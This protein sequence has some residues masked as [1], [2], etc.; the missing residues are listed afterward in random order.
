MLD[1]CVLQVGVVGAAALVVG[2]LGVADDAVVGEVGLTVFL[3]K[4]PGLLLLPLLPPPI[5]LRPEV[6]SELTL[7]PKRPLMSSKLETLPVRDLWPG[8]QV[9]RFW[10][11]VEPAAAR[12]LDDADEGMLPFSSAVY[13]AGDALWARLLEVGALGRLFRLLLMDWT[14]PVRERTLA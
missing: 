10:A 5:V 13:L 14:D 1:L 9:V 6:L 2:L 11:R 8:A 3:S 7:P 4:K 12:T